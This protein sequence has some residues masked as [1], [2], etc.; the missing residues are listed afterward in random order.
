MI[1]NILILGVVML[2]F[3]C[4]FPFQV[5]NIDKTGFASEQIGSVH[6]YND[7]WSIVTF[8]N[9]TNYVLEYEQQIESLCEIIK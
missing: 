9:I 3:V 7:V 5:T 4:S 1:D 6:L 2:E 8:T